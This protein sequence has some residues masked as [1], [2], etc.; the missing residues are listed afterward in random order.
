MTRGTTAV[1]AVGLALLTFAGPRPL[2]AQLDPSV[3]WETLVTTHFHIHFAPPLELAARRAAVNAERAYD[4]LARELVPPREPIDIV[5]ADNVDYSNGVT[6]PFP[7]NHIILYAHPPVDAQTLRF[8]GDWNTLLIQHELTHVFHLDRAR[9]WWSI[10]QHIMGRNPLVMPNLYT[11]AWLTEGLAVYYESRLT[12]FG[13]IAGTAHRTIAG[14][15]AADND[16]PRLDQVSLLAPLWPN[17]NGVYAYGSLLFQYLSDTRGPASVPRFVEISSGETVPFLLDRSAREAFGISFEVA[18]RQWRDS[19]L[20]AVRADSARYHALDARALT[21]EGN[22]A[23]F[24][25]WLNDTTVIFAADNQRELPGLYSVTLGGDERRL[26][27]RNSTDPNTPVP[28]APAATGDSAPPP[29]DV[30][31]SQLDYT[32]PYDLREDLYRTHDGHTTRLTHG[33]R[34]SY[35]DGR[36]DGTIVAVQDTPASTRLVLL[37]PGSGPNGLPL[38]LQAITGASPDTQWAE[39]RWSP[40]GHAIAAVRWIRGGFSEIVLL[41][42]TGRVDRIVS[43]AQAVES[44][45]AWTPD[46]R[47]LLF[48][49]DRTGRTE[50]Y[51]ATLGSDAAHDHIVRLGVTGAGTFY[52]APSPDGHDVAVSA[53]RGDGFHIA[54]MSFDSTAGTPVVPNAVPAVPIPV[55]PSAFDTAS[56]QSFRPLRGLV[57]RYWTPVTGTS[58]Q[59]YFE[60][61]AFTSAA[62]AVGRNSYE[63]QALY[64]VYQPHEPD[65]ALAYAYSGIGNPVLTASAAL[66]WDH[67]RIANQDGNTIGLLV[68]RSTT[69]SLAETLLRTRVR[70]AASWSVGGLLEFR[71]YFTTPS[72]LLNLLSP[73]FGSHPF[74]PSLFTTATWSNTEAPTQSISPENGVS[75][76]GTAQEQWQPGHTGGGSIGGPAPLLIGVADLYRALNLPGFA[77]HVIALRLAAGW[78]GTNAA[79]TFSAG[80]TT[81]SSLLLV[82]G[83][84]VGDQSRPFGVRGYG[85]GSARGTDAWAGSLEYRLPIAEPGRGWHLLPI[86]LGRVS[87]AAFADAGEAWC[88]SSSGNVAPACSAEDA[89]RRLMSSTGGELDLDTGLQYDVPFR[90]RLGFAVPTANRAF[91]GNAAVSPYVG[92]GL[93]F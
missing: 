2:A 24:P 20:A 88:P 72:P 36:A 26:A 42:S 60:I 76:S 46:G 54:L 64:N 37:T 83:V 68:H 18:W 69:L 32:S 1:T 10:A 41:D 16:L 43:R 17:G 65:I 21:H 85:A 49:S 8:Y 81:G 3:H 39:P 87:F 92:F 56:I 33:A 91:Y 9:G 84:S 78:E 71:D 74:Y 28:P 75:L 58:D 50:L 22:E 55:P 34:V 86:F 38:R 57:P 40:D 52:P 12:G 79:S 5:L 67:E 82:P 13:R 80:G 93:S 4:A 25:R 61:G 44:S 30:L 14:A 73:V 63:A 23:Y 77:H 15:A 66:S 51:L 70:T 62:D 59:G 47:R 89:E 6:T 35:A 31:F 11:P 29:A 7:T 19:V 48:T 90:F 27:R 45:P 53:Y